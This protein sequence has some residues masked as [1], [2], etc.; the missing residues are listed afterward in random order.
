VVKAEA[1]MMLKK[2]KSKIKLHQDLWGAKIYRAV[3]YCAKIK[4]MIL[5][6]RTRVNK[7]RSFKKER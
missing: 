6:P 1:T 7:P 4:T 5:Y 3:R 2:S